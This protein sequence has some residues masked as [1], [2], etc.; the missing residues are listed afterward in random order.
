MNA[1]GG[2]K[3][4][5]TRGATQGQTGGGAGERGGTGPRGSP[6]FVPHFSGSKRQ[7]EP[8]W[9]RGSGKKGLMVQ[10]GRAL[11]ER[12]SPVPLPGLGATGPEEGRGGL[13]SYVRSQEARSGRRK[14]ESSPPH[15]PWEFGAR[16]CE[17]S[18]C[19]RRYLWRW[20]SA[21]GRWR[22]AGGPVFL[23]GGGGSGGDADGFPQSPQL[24]RPALCSPERRDPACQ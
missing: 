24:N 12:G 4:E 17:D 7:A 10:G 22:S 9:D 11:L 6:D 1:A 18:F 13:G 3:W 23:R 14:E 2:T 21:K 19:Q 15:P 16:G 5:G 20:D 8:G